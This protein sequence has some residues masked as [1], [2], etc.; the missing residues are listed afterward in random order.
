[1]VEDNKETKEILDN[2]GDSQ[3][4]SYLAPWLIYALGFSTKPTINYRI[5]IGSFLEETENQV[6]FSKKNVSYILKG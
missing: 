4:F 3:V 1:M 5:G 2:K 6:N